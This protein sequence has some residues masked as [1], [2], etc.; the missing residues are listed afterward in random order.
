MNGQDGSRF[1]KKAVREMFASIAPCY[2]LVNRLMSWGQDNRW[3]RFAVGLACPVR[4]R[5]LD[6]ATGT[7][8]MAL[9]L[10]RHTG[11]VVGLDLC[12]EMLSRG[13]TKTEKKGLK[14]SVDF[15]MGDALALP[16][17]DN[18]FDCALNGFALRNVADI[19]LFLAELR[20]VVKPGG[21]VVCLELVRPAPGIIGA[22]YRFYLYKIVPVL[23]RW[24][25][26][27]GKA[28]R[29][30]PDS[31]GC[32]LSVVEFQKMMEGVGFRQ[33]GYRCLNLGTIAVHVGVK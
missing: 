25:S 6:V 29:Y 10:A 9:E 14:S 17:S 16:F 33:V 13:R 5:A 20:R 24:L 3:R 19:N 4:G 1:K 26:G 22:L 30:L 7:G 15:I 32:F 12:Q 2:D 27:N 8:D 23:G 18:S 31:V 28:Y 11:S 21:R